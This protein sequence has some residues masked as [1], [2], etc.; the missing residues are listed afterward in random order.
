M[1]RLFL[2]IISL[3]LLAACATQY[4]QAKKASANG[5]FDIKLQENVYQVLFNGNENTTAR[6]ANDFAL[7]RASEVCLENGYQ[8]FEIV[9]KSEDFTEKEVDTGIK[10]FGGTL[11]NIEN[12]KPKITLVVRCSKNMDLPM[13]ALEL[14]TSL[15][16]KYK[17]K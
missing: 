7:L 4:Q 16:N 6:T 14:K 12:T 11:S 13:H 9:S 5:Y 8:S 17:M 10:I 15:R 3:I 2:M 1:K